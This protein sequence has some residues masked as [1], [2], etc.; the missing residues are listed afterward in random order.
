VLVKAPSTTF[1]SSPQHLRGQP[2]RPHYNRFDSRPSPQTP[3]SYTQPLKMA[4][5]TTQIRSI[6]R[7]LLRELPIP[8]TTIPSRTQH[9]KLS[10]PSTIQ[11][12]LRD[13]IIK[14]SARQTSSQI[15][16]AE[17]FAQ[18]AQAQRTYI[19]LIE[20]YNPGMGMSEEERVRL[21]ARRIGMNLPVEYDAGKKE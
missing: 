20:R 5:P 21:S 2:S 6:Y 9:Q 1:P 12:R 16:Q 19:A 18:Y 10:A 11:Q 7:R 8:S 3:Q 4:Q 14:P 17:V 13:T 15:Q